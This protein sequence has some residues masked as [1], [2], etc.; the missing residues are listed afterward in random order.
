MGTL[1]DEIVKV[2]PPPK[3]SIFFQEGGGKDDSICGRDGKKLAVLLHLEDPG[4][5]GFPLFTSEGGGSIRLD[6]NDV[7]VL[8]GLLG[9]GIHGVGRGLI[10]ALLHRLQLV[11][12]VSNDVHEVLLVSHVNRNRFGNRFEVT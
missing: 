11:L 3:G 10:E 8:L 7:L 2:G 12:E 9:R 4:F 5:Q 1:P 6:V